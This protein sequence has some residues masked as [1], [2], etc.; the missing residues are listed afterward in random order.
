[1]IK[2]NLRKAVAGMG[3]ALA[4]LGAAQAADTVVTSP[5]QRITVTISQ[6]ADGPAY[7][8][9]FDGKPVLAPSPLGF[10]LGDVAWPIPMQSVIVE[11]A[12]RAQVDRSYELVVGKT[13]FVRD[14]YHELTLNL[15]NKRGSAKDPVKVI[16]R[17]YDDGMA[18]RYVV[19]SRMG[20][21]KPRITELSGFNFP[22]DYQCWGLNLGSF[23]TG[24]E[25]EYDPVNISKIRS[26]NRFDAP[27]VCKTGN[28]ASLAIA[29]ADVRDYGALYLSGRLDGGLGVAV[30]TA[31]RVSGPPVAVDRAPGTDVVS[32]WRVV[33]VGPSTGSLIESSILSNL[34]PPTAIK[35]TSWIKPGKASWDWWNDYAVSGVAKPGV[36]NE[37]A[38][39]FIDFSHQA[40]LEYMLLDAG[41]YQGSSVYGLTAG[42]DLTKSIP[43]IDIP[44]LVEYGRQRNVGLWVWMQWKDIDRQMPEALAQ[45]EKWGVKGIKVDFM[46]RDDQDM[47]AFYHR[48]VQMAAD[49]H[50]MV[51]LHGAFHPFGLQRT[52]PNLMTQ[53]GVFGAEMNKYTARVTATHNVTIPYTRMLLGPMD[54]TPGGFRNV[55]AA[56]FVVREH[57]PLVMTTRGQ[58]L[59]MYVVYESPFACVADAPDAYKDKSGLEFIARV[60][61]SWDETR[62]IGGDIGEYVAIARRKGDTWYVGAMTNEA[63]RTVQ[64]SL[65]FLGAG[66][67]D[68]TIQE[69]GD[70]P[71]ELRA[72]QAQVTSTGTMTLT[73]AGSGGAVARITPH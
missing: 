27:L 41:W 2:R 25:G 44:A 36:N 58:G 22:S 1:M 63:A 68:A 21:P 30:V 24:H 11:A 64:V 56:D 42:V 47:V 31:P 62:F 9:A 46:D 54:Y 71:T 16:V 59:A 14:R 55:K 73:L 29:E 4:S 43:A 20:A 23:N 50:L 45:F 18:F 15:R 51:N 10:I 48:L 70:M 39:R 17:A 28:G 33:M 26:F 57:L 35:D 32:P 72:R 5:N 66:A 3:L 67:F 65:G 60:P 49:H 52:F 19:P 12:A 61:T 40:G 8:V 6:S 13:R 53:E 34:N 37:T 38:K 69:D 7:S